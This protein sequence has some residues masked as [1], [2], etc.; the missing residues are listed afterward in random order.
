MIAK[1]W[2]ALLLALVTA[3]P[4]LPPESTYAA[5]AAR[6]YDIK[7]TLDYSK[8]VATVTE[9]LHYVNQTGVKLSSIAFTVVANHFGAFGLSS[10]EV[11]GVAVRTKAGDNWLEL[12]LP[13][14]IVPDAATEIQIVYRLAVP[15]QSDLRLGRSGGVIALGTWYPAVQTFRNGAWPK[16]RFIDNGDPFSSES[17]D[18]HVELTVKG[19]PSSLTVASSG[20]VESQEGSTYILSG[21]NLREFAVTLSSRYQTSYRVVGKTT[22]RS[23]YLPE[24]AAGGKAILDAAA[25]ALAWGNEH[26]GLYPY[27]TLNLAEM[28]VPSG[29]GQEYSRMIIFGSGDYNSRKGELTYLVAHEVFHQWFYGLVGNDQVDEPWLDEGFVTQLGYRFLY[30][31][32]PADYQRLWPVEV[33]DRYRVGVSNYGPHALDTTIYDYPNHSAYFAILYRKGALFA[34]DIRSALGDTLYYQMLRSYVGADRYHVVTSADLLL[35]VLDWLPGS[36]P[37]IIQKYFSSRTASAVLGSADYAS[38]IAF[39]AMPWSDTGQRVLESQ[40]LPDR[41]Y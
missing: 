2:M 4:L 30:S 10:A 1:L 7:A 15:S 22:V 29:S 5:D 41:V 40:I 23:F 39:W 24:Q 34:E 12:T 14:P 20:T 36:G 16:Y 6:S 25:A 3:I 13:K 38:T 11:D 27:E 18:Y 31:A 37:A 9:R 32:S 8:A 21:T 28:V 17:A 19:A 33:L 26:L 35:R